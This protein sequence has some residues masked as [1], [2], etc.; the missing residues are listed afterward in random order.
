MVSL[1]GGKDGFQQLPRVP[2]TWRRNDLFFFLSIPIP[3]PGKV[4]WLSWG[5]VATYNQ[6]SS[7][8]F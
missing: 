2:V 3:I 5:Q 7:V 4:F 8:R 1:Q 6:E